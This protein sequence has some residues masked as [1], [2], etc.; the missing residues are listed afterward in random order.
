MRVVHGETGVNV[1]AETVVRE[2]RLAK[3]WLLCELRKEHVD[4]V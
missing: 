4:E 2:W 1:S 3:D